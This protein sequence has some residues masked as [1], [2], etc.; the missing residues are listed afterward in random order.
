MILLYS[1]PFERAANSILA[2][3][4]IDRFPPLWSVVLGLAYNFIGLTLGTFIGPFRYDIL[5][6]SSNLIS[7]GS[8]L[9]PYNSIAGPILTAFLL[10]LGIQ[11]SQIA[12]RTSI[13]KIAPKARNRVNTVFMVAVFCGQLTGTAVGNRVYAVGGWRASGGASMGFIAIAMCVALSRGPWE[14][15][16]I[17]WSGGWGR[18]MKGGNEEVGVG[19]ESVVADEERNGQT[20]GNMA[21]REGA[22]EDGSSDTLVEG[23]EM[24]IKDT[25]ISKSKEER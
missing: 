1:F 11:T 18:K 23:G 20:A 9:T 8:L 13:Y 14:K 21:M 10:D 19:G 6:L 4:M 12:N 15:G 3:I 24:E 22:T 7:P 2:R 17:G 16:W 5:L 25:N